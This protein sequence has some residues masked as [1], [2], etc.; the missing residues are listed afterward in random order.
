[1]N[2]YAV[3]DYGVLGKMLQAVAQAAKEIPEG[4]SICFTA[5]KNTKELDLRRSIWSESPVFL[6]LEIKGGLHAGR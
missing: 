4:K 3:V 5:N 2:V 1:M 6:S